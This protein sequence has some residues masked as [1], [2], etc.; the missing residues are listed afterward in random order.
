MRRSQCLSHS[1]CKGFITNITI[2]DNLPCRGDI[3]EQSI[4][5]WGKIQGVSLNSSLS[6]LTIILMFD[7]HC[8]CPLFSNAVTSKHSEMTDNGL[9]SHKSFKWCSDCAISS[10][11]ILDRQNVEHI[12]CMKQCMIKVHIRKPSMH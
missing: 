10:Y 11:Q 5:S 12:A 4:L 2:Y 9:R 7:I 6:S 3:N 8:D 1:G